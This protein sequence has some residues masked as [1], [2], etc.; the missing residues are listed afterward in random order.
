MTFS[1]CVSF[2]PVMVKEDKTHSNKSSGITPVLRGGLPRMSKHNVWDT[3][4]SIMNLFHHSILNYSEKRVCEVGWEFAAWDSIWR[5][6]GVRVRVMVW[7]RLN[8]PQPLP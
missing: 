8:L 5:V 7:V 3:Y 1:S 2:I 4:R 6:T